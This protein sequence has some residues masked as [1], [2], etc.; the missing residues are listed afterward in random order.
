MAT[1][2]QAVSAFLEGAPNR[3]FASLGISEVVAPVGLAT[4]IYFVGLADTVFAYLRHCRKWNEQKLAEKLRK[5]SAAI[6]IILLAAVAGE[7][8]RADSE[9]LDAVLANDIVKVE[10]VLEESGA[11]AV[12]LVAGS[13]VTPLHLAAAMNSKPIAGLLIAAGAD[14]DARTDGGFTPLHWAARKDAVE[15]AELLI[16]MGADINSQTDNGIT[17]LHWAA[18]NNSTNAIKLLVKSGAWVNA[19]T[20]SGLTPLH[21]ALM[22]DAD[23]AAV[24]LAHKIVSEDMDKKLVRREP[25]YRLQMPDTNSLQ[26]PVAVAAETQ[27]APADVLEQAPATNRIA[28]DKLLI[29]PI[30]QGQ[31]LSFVWIEE[32]ELWVGRYEVTNGQYRRFKP[33]HN[34]LFCED[35]SLNEDTQPVVYV[36]WNDAKAF[37]GWLN[38]NYSDRVPR[39]HEFRL[40]TELEW[41]AFTRCGDDRKYPWGDRWPPLYGNFSGLSSRRHLVEWI[42]I[43][44]YDDDY[45]VS[46]PVSA[47]G[48]NEWGIFGLA[49]NVWEWCEDSYGPA[50]QFKIRKGG[51]WDFDGEPSLHVEARGFDQPDARYDN[52]G[53]RIVVAM[54][55]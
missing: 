39:K 43:K 11:E 5:M 17:P 54:K 4:V 52:I 44:N 42:G 30:W 31:E 14:V 35:F 41:M 3:D 20:E 6:I 25:I 53:F 55:E 40:P 38:E 16:N 33:A 51:S 15:T 13:G 8:A 34:S 1:N 27:A 29:V 19:L 47:S 22:Q 7:R 10:T 2:W 28:P 50:N 49:G 23:E 21:W 46:C 24:A 36:S 45:P 26:A 48:M 32:L 37:C 12:N 9:L 18:Q